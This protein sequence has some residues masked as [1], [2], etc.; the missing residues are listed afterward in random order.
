[1]NPEADGQRV[2]AYPALGLV[3]FVCLEIRKRDII[4]DRAT[5]W[6]LESFNSPVLAVK[7]PP[8]EN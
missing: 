6:D 3:A 4:H 7:V 8:P 2:R 5:Y 1:M